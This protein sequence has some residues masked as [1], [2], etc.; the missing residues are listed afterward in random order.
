[1]VGGR[2]V[3]W[4]SVVPLMRAGRLDF[5]GD[6]DVRR[7]VLMVFMSRERKGKVLSRG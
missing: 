2:W 3:D 4:W 7:E 1:M 5:W 6:V